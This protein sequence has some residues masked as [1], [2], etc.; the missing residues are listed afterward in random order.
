MKK[1]LQL[2]T[3]F[4]ILQIIFLSVFVQAERPPFKIFTTEE[5]LAHDSVN[6]IVR[7]S[8][9]FLWF[10]TAEGVSRF[11]GANF[12]NY[13]QDDGLPHRN[14]ND[15]IETEDGEYLAATSGGLAAFNPNGKGYRW[16]ILGY[17][18]EQTG[19]ELPMF[20]TFAPAGD[21]RRKSN[22]LSLG[23]DRFGKIWA[24]TANGLFRIEKSGADWV[25]AEV[26]NEEFKNKGEEFQS[27]LTTSDSPFLVA[28]SFAVYRVTEESELK[29]LTNFG[30]A[31]MMRDAD[32]AIWL[33][34][35]AT[36]A[37]L[38][39]FAFENDSLRLLQT[40]T[41]RD[42]LPD[43]S[44][45]YALKQTSD[46]RIFV[47]MHDGLCEFLPSAKTGESKFRRLE[48][49]KVTS[50]EEDAGGNLWLGT[51]LK[52]AWKMAGGDL[53]IF[54]AED[55]F[56]PEDDLRAIYVSPQNEIFI[57][58]LPNKIL[59]LSGGQFKTIE[60]LG[61]PK[62]SWSWH[63]LDF[64][65]K[66]GEWWMPSGKG[67]FRYPKIPRPEDLDR[68]SPKKI[69]T[70]KDGLPGEE[71]FNLF[72]DSRGDVWFTIVGAENALLRWIRKTEKIEN[73]TTAD[74]LPSFNGPISFAEDKT[75]AIW[76]GFYFGGLARFH[77]GKFDF[78]TEKDGFP[79][80]LVGDILKDSTDRLWIGTSGRGLFRIDETR[81]EKPE[82]TSVSTA[83]GLSSNQII[84]L[85]EDRFGRIYAGTGRGINRLDRNGKIKIFTQAD[86]LPSNYITRCAADKKGFLWFVSQNTLVRFAPEIEKTVAPPTVFIDKIS[87]GGVW[88]KISALG[89]TEIDLPELDSNQNQIQIDFFALVFGAGENIRYQYRLNKQDWSNPSRQQT[90][91]L[92]LAAGKHEFEVRAVRTDGVASEK[93]AAVFFKI[94]PPV[95]ARPWFI[96]LCVLGIFVIVL[97]I[98]RYRTANLRK[99]NAALK[100]AK[101]AEEDLR[102]SREERLAEL[103]Q[104]RSRIATDLHDD[105]GATLT[106][107]AVLSEVAQ[108]QNR[109]NGASEPLSKISE[110]SNE[111]VGTMSD[112][113]WAI[114]PTRDH[115]SDLTQRMRRF[116]SDVLSPRG[117][118]FKFNAPNFDEEIVV[119][120][121]LR[122]EVYLIF[123]ESINNI[124]KHSGAKNVIIE[125]QI[126]DTDL[127]LKISDDGKG[128]I[129]GASGENESG[130]GISS[131][132]KRA[133]E[134]NGEIEIVSEQG[135]KIIL[136]LP[137]E[138]SGLERE[139]PRLQ[140]N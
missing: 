97:T 2:S 129:Y 58:A 66:D 54:S 105:I 128:F 32:G 90:I 38:Q 102:K 14:V 12:R 118:S 139:R 116:A 40:Y 67:L 50:L 86:G 78:F 110:V 88:Q 108:A 74:G 41:K 84:C 60:P 130:N 135:V 77:D 43:D 120:T 8:R 132:K 36:D 107:I 51:E 95:W 126:S 134:M 47:G 76:F 106:Q 25:F 31:S 62:R 64:I 34:T 87:A 93:T 136:R 11:D 140:S 35:G 101:R 23:K 137:L 103:E 109:G 61:L 42:G 82:F 113:V 18:L 72:E 71:I 16:N 70:K 104:V 125:L 114:N 117:I 96:A 80:S 75:G 89:E 1:H 6:K 94:P 59:H 17:R 39:V 26:V 115:L 57:P 119:K 69:Y 65:S 29:K 122:R 83:E 63:F 9:G 56:T 13:A 124:V 127:I 21:D 131:M 15:F 22:I 133:A 3:A 91:N 123:K 99:I 92:D 7:D 52:G 112:I 100:E 81:A 55:G 46:G 68:T 48:K 79:T 4:I 33:D 73:F 121:N 85:T 37:G 53:T 24:G 111:L 45:F 49:S 19:D 30:A 28:S 27:F 98:Y 5:G 138:R 44:F 20:R 10:C